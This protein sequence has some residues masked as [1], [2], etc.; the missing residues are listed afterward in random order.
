MPVTTLRDAIRAVKS[1]RD[2]LLAEPTPDKKRLRRVRRLLRDL[3]VQ[4]GNREPGDEDDDI[5]DAFRAVRDTQNDPT[6]FVEDEWREDAVL[7]MQKLSTMPEDEQDERY[8]ADN[9]LIRK[10]QVRRVLRQTSENADPGFDPV[11]DNCYDW[12]ERFF[13]DF[14]DGRPVDAELGSA[15]AALEGGALDSQALEQNLS[16]LEQSAKRLKPPSGEE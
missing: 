2:A 3:Q 15:I 16:A 7:L 5:R 8:V 13:D 4:A 11:R 14:R 6:L 1:Q 9:S 12:L 10:D